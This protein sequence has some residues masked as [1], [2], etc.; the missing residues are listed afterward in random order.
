MSDF[1][2][3]MAATGRVVAPTFDDWQQAADVVTSIRVRSRGW[4][5]KLPALVNDILIAL[6]A[7]RVGA[8]L[9]TYNAADFRLIHHHADF[10]LRVLAP[11]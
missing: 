4:R 6:C 11:S 5:S 10:E 1:V 2:R 3:P 9:C 7:R 8:V